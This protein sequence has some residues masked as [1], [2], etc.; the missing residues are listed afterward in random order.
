[1]S[2]TARHNYKIEI[3][4]K[5]LDDCDFESINSIKYNSKHNYDLKE[6]SKT[7]L[8]FVAYINI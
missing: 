2:L 7:N 4:F 5:I 6:N 1:M 8:F 3:L